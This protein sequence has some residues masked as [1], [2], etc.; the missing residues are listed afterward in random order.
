MPNPAE[1]HISSVEL[2]APELFDAEVLDDAETPGREVR[3]VVDSIDRGLTTDPA[4]FNPVS[5]PTGWFYPKKGDRAI[6]ARH[7]DGPDTI[8]EWW[9]DPDAVPDHPA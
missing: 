4:R 2:P 9:P 5:T 1:L 6:V 8:I 7:T 3:C